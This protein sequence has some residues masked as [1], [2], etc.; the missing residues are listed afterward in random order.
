MW[1]WWLFEECRSLSN[2]IR[3][4]VHYRKVRNERDPF[5][6][7][8]SIRLRDKKRKFFFF[9]VSIVATPKPNKSNLKVWNIFKKKKKWIKPGDP[10]TIIR[11]AG[12]DGK[13]LEWIGL[14]LFQIVLTHLWSEQHRPFLF[15]FYIVK[16][17]NSV[18]FR[19]KQLIKL[20][21]TRIFLFYHSFVH[22][23]KNKIRTNIKK[24][25]SK[26]NS[27]SITFNCTHDC[28]YLYMN[29]KSIWPT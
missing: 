20:P 14:I 1:N 21:I 18:L 5:R 8:I 17:I 16:T 27:A 4:E 12:D 13:K 2:T 25:K 28:K 26:C 22:N 24:F 3:G 9:I 23:T 7:S 10:N 6:R 19:T 15:Y 11:S 29:W